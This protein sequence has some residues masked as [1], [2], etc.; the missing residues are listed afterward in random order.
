MDEKYPIERT[1]LALPQA[2]QAIVSLATNGEIARAVAEAH[3][4][5]DSNVATEAWRFLSEV[6]ANLQ[7]WDDAVSAI[8]NALRHRPGSR[9][10]RLARALLLEQRG[11]DPA[12]LA[13]LESLAREARDSP[14]LLVH[15]AAQLTSAGRG[16]EAEVLLLQSLERWPADATLH[17]QLARLRW[18]LGAGLEAM[19]PVQQAIVDQ[20][21]ELHLRLVAA[22]LL[23]NADAGER[24]LG[25]L[26]RGLEL[27]P[28]SPIFRTSI[29]AL[30]EGMDRLGEAMKY[31]RDAHARAPRS[32]AVRR[33]LATALLRTGAA[34]EARALFDGLLAQL[35]D[36]QLLIAQRAIALRLLGDP[37]YARLYDYPRV[38]KTFTLTPPAQFADIGAFN[39]G[40]ARELAAL[41]RAVQHPLEQSLRG[42]SQTE[43]H[44]PRDNP[45]FAAFF[46][47][48]DAPIRE[49]I[50]A[51]QADPLHPL[52]RRRRA[53]YRISGSW[54]VQL[55][56]GGYHIDHVH[57]RGWLSSA[58][59]VSLPDVSDADSRAGWL[60]FGEPGVR[61][62]GCGAEHFVKPAEGMLVLFPSYLWHGTVAFATGGPRL[63]A[64]FDVVPA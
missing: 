51:L 57:P 39:A 38:V 4:I 32:V 15:L 55:R 58:Y 19:R 48:L 34:A 56:A 49:Y 47:M 50:A 5:A 18:Q 8:E 63:T 31:L 42:G 13:E 11:D 3:G 41:H 30:L 35:P 40:F 53:D 1:T 7:R 9:P 16:D 21:R 2:L 28:D 29:G 12:A 10:L 44:L 25:L 52:D 27:A 20:P 22:D 60:K 36:D 17:T 46:A 23:R 61:V 14:Q 6:N 24:A 54:S 43:R 62:P 37:E 64:A 33:N 59:Y 45:W 26:E